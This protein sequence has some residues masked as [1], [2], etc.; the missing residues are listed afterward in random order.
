MKRSEIGAHL[1][2]Q[3][4]LMLETNQNPK[5]DLSKFETGW[6]GTGA[7]QQSRNYLEIPIPFRLQSF[8]VALTLQ[9][10]D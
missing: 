4:L 10:T 5:L 9:M 2:V 1:F 8:G 7:T 3:G 6:G